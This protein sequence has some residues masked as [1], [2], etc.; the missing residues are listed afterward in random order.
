MDTCKLEIKAYIKPA[1]ASLCLE[2][3][4]LIAVSGD[5]EVTKTD[6]KADEGSEALSRKFDFMEDIKYWPSGE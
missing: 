4:G 5:P 1:V 6:E 2:N 3:E